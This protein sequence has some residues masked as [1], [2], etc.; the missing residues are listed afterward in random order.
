VFGWQVIEYYELVVLREPKYCFHTRLAVV[1]VVRAGGGRAFDG[2]W[3]LAV[4]GWSFWSS[5]QFLPVIAGQKKGRRS[6]RKELC[7]QRGCVRAPKPFV[8]RQSAV[9]ASLPV[10]SISYPKPIAKNV[11]EKIEIAPLVV[12]SISKKFV[13]NFYL[14]RSSLFFAQIGW[15]L[16]NR[17]PVNEQQFPKNWKGKITENSFHRCFAVVKNRNT[18]PARGR[19]FYFYLSGSIR[20]LFTF[21]NRNRLHR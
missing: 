13:L 10:G 6:S 15:I 9:R 17:N 12:V 20:I 3:R 11:P 2:A 14:T 8:L 5:S 21:R 1:A 19:R 16:S 7:M 18:P 4:L